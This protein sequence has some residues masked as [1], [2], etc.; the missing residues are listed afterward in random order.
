MNISWGADHRAV[1][2]A[3]LAQFSNAWKALL[4]NPTKMLLRLR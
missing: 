1:D 2:G 3:A 4:E